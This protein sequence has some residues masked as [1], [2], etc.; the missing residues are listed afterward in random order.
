[1]INEAITMGLGWFKFND[2]KPPSTALGTTNKNI[3]CI[4][5]ITKFTLYKLNLGNV[6][7]TINICICK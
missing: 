1:M 7:S 2:I 5:Y 4:T 6:C 3:Y